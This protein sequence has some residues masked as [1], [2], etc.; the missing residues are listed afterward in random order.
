MLRQFISPPYDAA[1]MGLEHNDLE[2]IVPGSV[3]AAAPADFWTDCGGVSPDL[4]CSCCNVCC[5]ST[6]C[7]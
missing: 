6:E 5:P 3:C 2:G 7:T 1:G 4:E